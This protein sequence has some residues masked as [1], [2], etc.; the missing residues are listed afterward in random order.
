VPE[1][2]ARPSPAAVASAAVAGMLTILALPIASRLAFGP[3]LV[4]ALPLML[5]AVGQARG[6]PWLLRAAVVTFLLA[7]AAIAFSIGVLGLALLL[8]GPI[9]SVILVGQLLR[10]LDLIATAAFLLTGTI[11]LIAGLAAAQQGAM[12]IVIGGAATTGLVVVAIRLRTTA[13]R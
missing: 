9:A 5:Y 11:V 13:T 12:P 10:E 6:R 1:T 8:V 3:L 4:F 7:A 2:A